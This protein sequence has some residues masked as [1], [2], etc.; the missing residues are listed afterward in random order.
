MRNNLFI[1][2]IVLGVLLS[3]QVKAQLILKAGAG[4][5]AGTQKLLLENVY[6]TTYAENVYGSFGGN[7]GVNLSAG[8]EVNQ[9]VD[10]EFDFGY[11]H[12]RTKEI[13]LGFFGYKTYVGRL[14]YLGPS[15]VFKTSVSD[16]VS[17]YAKLGLF[18]G[19]PLTK[20]IVGGTEKKFRGGIPIGYKGALGL[21]YNLGNSFKIFTEVY[22]QSMIYTPARRRELNGDVTRLRDKIDVPTPSKQELK[23]HFFS[24]GAL[25]VNAGIKIII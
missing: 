25:G 12:G 6:T 19:L 8:Y 4:Y 14:I 23:H 2:L 10:F 9:Y 21:D 3:V 16:K 18:T 20:V 5:G 15:M 1:V 17:P 13:D 7:L 24:F 11:Q 22:H